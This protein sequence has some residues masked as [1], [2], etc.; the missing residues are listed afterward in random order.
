MSNQQ[1]KMNLIILG[2]WYKVQK[3]IIPA[4]ANFAN[5]Y[6]FSIGEIILQTAIRFGANLEVASK[7][8]V[9]LKQQYI[10]RADWEL[11]ML[12]S[13]LSSSVEC[14]ILPI[15]K[16]GT[17]SDELVQIGKMIGSWYDKRI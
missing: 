11:A 5:V 1:N 10:A 14:K 15:K 12:K 4:V 3:I 13:A 7:V 8:N 17:I 2:K 16:Y 6:K 9:K